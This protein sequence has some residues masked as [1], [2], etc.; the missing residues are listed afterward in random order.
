MNLLQ[1][2]SSAAMAPPQNAQL[3]S[4]RR[5]EY[6]GSKGCCTLY[7]DLPR[8]VRLVADLVRGKSVERCPGHTEIYAGKAAVPI[9]KV[10]KSAAANAENNYNL[11]RDDLYIRRIFIDEGPII[12]ALPPEA[13]QG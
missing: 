13:W 1:H 8:K 5:S 12:Q 10:I 3:H 9:A 4:N 11:D 7:M 2:A 6:G